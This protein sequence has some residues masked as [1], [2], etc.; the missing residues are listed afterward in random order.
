MRKG[1]GE[2][3]EGGREE[4]K[5]EEEGREGEGRGGKGDREGRGKATINQGRKKE[6]EIEGWREK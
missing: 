2:K 1:K 6:E 3:R 4:K 5:K